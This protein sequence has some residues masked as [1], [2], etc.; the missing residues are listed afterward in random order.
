[1][2]ITNYFFHDADFSG[3]DIFMLQHIITRGGIN[4]SQMLKFYLLLMPRFILAYYSQRLVTCTYL[5]LN[6]S[7]QQLI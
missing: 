1:M 5:H 3:I 7:K 2:V 6:K 4:G